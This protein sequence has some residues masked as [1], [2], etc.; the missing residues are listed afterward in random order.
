[1]KKKSKKKTVLKFW[2]SIEDLPIERWFKVD[3]KNDL[4]YLLF[5]P[6]KLK[7]HEQIILTLTWDNMLNEFIDEFG[8]G[9][10]MKEILRIKRKIM[11]LKID[12]VL[13]K[14]NHKTKIAFESAL[15]AEEMKKEVKKETAKESNFE[16]LAE[17]SKYM[18]FFIDPKTISVK[19][20][21]HYV[22]KL[23]KEA[24]KNERN[25]FKKTE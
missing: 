16:S 19:L 21:F 4:S 3:E 11:M 6:R 18:G 24:E 14:K 5:E 15:L 20:Y 9:E 1:M 13:N 8:I 10:K 23:N 25:E 17:I 7:P 2:K 12:E 22:R